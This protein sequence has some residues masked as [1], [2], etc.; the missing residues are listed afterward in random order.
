MYI[1]HISNASTPSPSFFAGLFTEAL[2]EAAPYKGPSVLGAG[3]EIK[4]ERQISNL[5]VTFLFLTHISNASTPSPYFFAG[6]F[7]EA[8]AGVAPYKGLSVL[9]V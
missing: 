5:L 8:L 6:L 2:A 1:S 3:G 4:P 9:G 7:T